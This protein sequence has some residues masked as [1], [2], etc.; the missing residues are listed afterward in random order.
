VFLA[1]H[2]AQTSPRIGGHA[3]SLAPWRAEICKSNGGNFKGRTVIRKVGLLPI[4][5]D[6]A[7][8]DRDEGPVFVNYVAVGGDPFHTGGVFRVKGGHL[9]VARFAGT[10]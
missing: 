8:L 7:G 10:R 3:D 1:D 2:A 6:Q 4:R 9:R 5:A